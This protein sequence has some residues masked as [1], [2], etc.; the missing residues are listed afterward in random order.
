VLHGRGFG[1]WFPATRPVLGPTQSSI[2]RVPGTVS[3]EVNRQ[4]LEADHSPPFNAEVKKRGAI[5]PLF[6][7]VVFHD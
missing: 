1:I 3:P 6:P 7:G 5:P 4:K 2:E